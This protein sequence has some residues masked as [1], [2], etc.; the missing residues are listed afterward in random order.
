VTKTQTEAFLIK[1]KP[2][3]YAGPRSIGLYFW[4]FAPYYAKAEGRNWVITAEYA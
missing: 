3:V 4:T 2:R 1:I